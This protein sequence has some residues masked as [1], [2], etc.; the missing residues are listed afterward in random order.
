MENNAY[1]PRFIALWENTEEG[2][3][4]RALQESITFE[5]MSVKTISSIE[6]ICSGNQNLDIVISELSRQWDK[7]EV[8]SLFD[9]LIDKKV[10]VNENKCNPHIEKGQ[11][12]KI[13]TILSNK[14]TLKSL[15]LPYSIIYGRAAQDIWSSG[16]D[17]DETI[18]VKK[19]ISEIAEWNA[20][21]FPNNP[22][23]K[24]YKNLDTLKVIH[25]YDIVKY[26]S[27]QYENKNFPLKRFNVEDVHTWIAAKKLSTNEEVLM[28]SDHVLFGCLQKKS[29]YTMST[30]SGCAA[31]VEKNKAITHAI[32]E[33]IERDAFMIFWLN[34]LDRDTIKNESLPSEIKQRIKAIEKLGYTITI[35]DITLDLASVILIAVRDKK[36]VYVT[37]G[38]ASSNDVINMFDSALCEV[39][40]S[41]LHILNSDITVN[42]EII[43]EDIISSVEHEQ[44]HQQ[45][46][47]A[48][49][50]DFIFNINNK[51]SFEEFCMKYENKK[52]IAVH[53]REM[54]FN[55]YVIDAT[56]WK[57][58]V[59]LPEH[60]Y[61]VRVIIPGL[62]PISFGY[63]RE[64]LGMERIYTVP[65]TLGFRQNP[66]LYENINRTPHPFN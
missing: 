1:F 18:A 60:R 8:I 64:P 6:K 52:P 41:L 32:Y 7:D 31:H 2:I 61:I 22:I 5:G 54:N 17:I 47:Y 16:K 12:K 53:L 15:S 40:V 14:E 63:G 49:E 65:I 48:V 21:I 58:N 62:V 51:I 45:P 9:F 10:I 4:I 24:S 39:E 35:K 27:L 19:L 59:L 37:S 56:E 57:I 23:S 11:L 3:K 44:F 50:T 43:M 55:I 33:L 42:A 66:V 34:K 13:E 29:V 38:L 26:K 36:G 30:S 25:P 28:L 20:W 46:Q